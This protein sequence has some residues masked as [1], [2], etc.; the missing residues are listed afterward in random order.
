MRLPWRVAW[1]IENAAE[2]PA[3]ILRIEPNRTQFVLNG[4][5]RSAK[6]TL[7]IAG[8]PAVRHALAAA[9]TAFARG[10]SLDTVVSG[11][12]SV[13]GVPG[14]LDQIDEGQPFGVR[15]DEAKTAAELAD[16]LEPIRS[17]TTGR[18]HC[19]L[20]AE[21][22][23]DRLERLPLGSVAEAL[24]DRL[25]FTTDNPRTDNPDQI[26]DDLLAGLRRPGRARGEPTRNLAIQATLG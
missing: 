20:G 6:I 5:D 26:L 7:R 22:L 8:R 4:F 3:E 14:R 13:T 15:I 1:G 18:V 23:R 16:A 25:T 17:F 2:V 12:E 10:I 24:A 11:L 9:A 21:G 19:V